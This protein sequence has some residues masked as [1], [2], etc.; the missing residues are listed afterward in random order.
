MTDRKHALKFTDPSLAKPSFADECDINNIVE[1][2]TR[3]GVLPEQRGNPQYGDAPDQTMYEAACIQAEVRSQ[4][5]LRA[6][7]AAP[8]PEEGVTPS[9]NEK[10][11]PAASQ[12]V[13]EDSPAPQDAPQDAAK[14][15]SSG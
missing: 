11:P 4:E 5:A 10:T 15:E 3:T 2:F 14:D 13:S 1:R 7:Q 6:A 9:E 8:E 12:A